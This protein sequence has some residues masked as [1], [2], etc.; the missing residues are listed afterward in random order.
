MNWELVQFYKP[1]D[2][3]GA[4]LDIFDPLVNND[5]KVTIVDLKFKGY[6][7]NCFFFGIL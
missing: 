1:M 4:V 5:G 7:K 2:G 3:L 6:L